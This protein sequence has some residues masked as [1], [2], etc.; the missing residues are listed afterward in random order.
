MH[1]S[2]GVHLSFVRSVTMDSWSAA[3]MKMM[4]LGGNKA[5]IDFFKKHGVNDLSIPE[6]YDT[7]AA[8][9]YRERCVEGASCSVCVEGGGGGESVC[10]ECGRPPAHCVCVVC[11][12]ATACGHSGTASRPPRRCRRRLGPAL[13]SPPLRRRPA[14][15]LRTNANS[16]FA[17]KRKTASNPSLGKAA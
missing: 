16:G 17:A 13:G 7:P 15:S 3:Q 4:Q 9:L 2:L 6:K 11:V 8:E 12:H 10:Q 1:R 14:V 5:L